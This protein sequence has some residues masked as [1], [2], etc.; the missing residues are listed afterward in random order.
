MHL[1]RESY[2]LSHQR[3]RT[4]SHKACIVSVAGLHT[5]TLNI[6]SHLLGTVWFCCSIVRFASACAHPLAQDAVAVFVYL[7]ATALCFAGSTLYH[8]FADHVH[9]SSW[10]RMDH[11]GIVCTIW[12]SSL[13]FVM[14]AFDCWPGEQWAYAG[15]VTSAAAL[16]LARLAN[17]DDHGLHGRKQRLSTHL[18]F[19]G[20]ALLPGLHRWYL[21]TQGPHAGLLEAFWTLVV[22]N[23]VGGI[24]YATHLLDKA[25]GMELGMPDASHHLMHVMVVAGACVYE[26]GLLSVYQARASGAARLCV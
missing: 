25:I 18:V 11:I 24:I 23:S 21:H 12:A 4:S 26:R 16:S 22:V 13:S 5:E 7:G 20:L 2:P 6:W 9:A 19:G 10:L 15:L 1:E 17:V 3:L 14:F 8:V